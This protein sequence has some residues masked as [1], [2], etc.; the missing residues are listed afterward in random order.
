MDGS[1]D[2]DAGGIASVISAPQWSREALKAV[3]GELM[4]AARALADPNYSADRA[5]GL[6]DAKLD[7]ILKSQDESQAQVTALTDEVRQ[8]KKKLSRSKLANVLLAICFVIGNVSDVGGAVSTV[9]DL[10]SWVVDQVEHGQPPSMP[11]TTPT[12]RPLATE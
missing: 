11:P 9:S 4:E 8:L 3:Q 10:I 12:R 5:Y 2:F 1:F 7:R 6:L